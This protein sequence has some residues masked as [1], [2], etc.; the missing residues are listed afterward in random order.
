MITAY[1]DWSGLD[2][3]DIF[4]IMKSQKHILNQL[5]H[6]ALRKW[7]EFQIWYAH[8]SCYATKTDQ[9]P[10]PPRKTKTST[11]SLYGL[12]HTFGMR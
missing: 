3:P 7:D 1:K 4:D 6:F 2:E 11:L 10:K 5:I 12:S 9:I 8:Q